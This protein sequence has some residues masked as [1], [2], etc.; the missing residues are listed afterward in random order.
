MCV[1]MSLVP[2]QQLLLD[3]IRHLSEREVSA[4]RILSVRKLAARIVSIWS[5]IDMYQVSCEE[6]L[7]QLVL[8]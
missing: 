5:D 7:R 3:V 6:R 4:F 8:S 2:L 1:L